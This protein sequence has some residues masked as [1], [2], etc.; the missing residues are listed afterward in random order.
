MFEH[1]V[2]CTGDNIEKTSLSLGSKALGAREERSRVLIG[3]WWPTR[4]QFDTVTS[5]VTIESTRRSR[6]SDSTGNKIMMII[7]P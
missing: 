1:V 5:S 4:N 7:I 2:R 6:Q 3:L